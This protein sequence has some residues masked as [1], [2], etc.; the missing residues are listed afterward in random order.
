MLLIFAIGATVATL[1]TAGSGPA[2]AMRTRVKAERLPNDRATMVRIPLGSYRSLY[3]AGGAATR[4]AAFALDCE[5]VTRAGFLDF[6]R[7]NP[8]WRRGGVTREFANREY[9]ANWRDDFDAGD[10]TDL[11]RPVTAVSRYAATVTERQCS[12]DDIAAYA[13]NELH[14]M[15]AEGE[16]LLLL[17]T[18]T[19]RP[20][21]R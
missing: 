18:I 6:V 20:G 16:T 14:S 8:S 3:A 10:A 2:G 1:L 9:L 17:A 11:R 19:P 13:P 4:V 15:R 12:T 5:P 7:A 21:E